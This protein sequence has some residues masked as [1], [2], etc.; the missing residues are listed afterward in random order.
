M[1]HGV[2]LF[3]DC[4][5]P[6]I[7]IFEASSIP[8]EFNDDESV[9][10]LDRGFEGRDDDSPISIDEVSFLTTIAV[11][12]RTP[13][14]V[15][16]SFEKYWKEKCDGDIHF[17]VLTSDMNQIQ[18]SR[19]NELNGLTEDGWSIKANFIAICT[20]SDEARNDAINIIRESELKVH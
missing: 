6:I 3:R 13:E 5:T 16:D 12:S 18:E 17:H 15:L 10:L 9:I 14:V 11:L 2:N 7:Y 20:E 19:A 8:E 4:M 1:L